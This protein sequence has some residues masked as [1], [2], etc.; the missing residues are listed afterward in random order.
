VA[1]M[2]QELYSQGK[3]RDYP[4]NKRVGGAQWRLE[5]CDEINHMSFLEIIQDSSLIHAVGWPLRRLTTL[6]SD[7]YFFTSIGNILPQGTRGS[8]LLRSVA[9]TT[10]IQ[11]SVTTPKTLQSVIIHEALKIFFCGVYCT[12][13]GVCWT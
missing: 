10:E 11:H 1:T 3:Y 8:M 2:S 5:P 9:K 6:Q 7:K 4:L 12:V 13:F